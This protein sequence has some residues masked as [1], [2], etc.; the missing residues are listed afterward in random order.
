MIKNVMYRWCF[1]KD[2]VSLEKEE[3]FDLGDNVVL[4]RDSDSGLCVEK[5]SI[6]REGYYV[7]LEEVFALNLD[8][9]KAEQFDFNELNELSAVG[10]LKKLRD[11]Q[12]GGA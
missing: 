3:I 10:L 12:L 9:E 5:V 4:R 6:T 2:D 1:G 11:L 8:G 7:Y